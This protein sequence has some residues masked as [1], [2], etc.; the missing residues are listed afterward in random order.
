MDHCSK[1]IIPE[2]APDFDL[3][4][5]DPQKF[6]SDFDQMGRPASIQNVPWPEYPDKPDVQFRIAWY[7]NYLLLKYY[8]REREILGTF[9]Q[10]GSDVFKDSCVELFLSPENKEYYYNFEFNCLGSVLAQVGVERKEREVPEKSILDRIVRI[11]SLGTSPYHHYHEGLVDEAPSW[12]LM[13][14]IPTSAF[15]KESYDTFKGL[16]MQG[17]L[18]KCGD[19]LQTPHYLCWN[20]VMSES[21]DFHKTEFFGELWFS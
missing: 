1:L 10:D 12:S 18:Y 16:K 20:P 6:S 2:V 17:N 5:Q 14:V 7:Q 11:P 19:L 4:S 9:T 8:V 3:L 13:L 15:F 21:P